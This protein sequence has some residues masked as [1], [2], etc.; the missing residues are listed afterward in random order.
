MGATTTLRDTGNIPGA[1]QDPGCGAQNPA[2]HPS[3]DK[4]APG[5]CLA[6]S[7]QS[8]ESH[9]DQGSSQS[10]TEGWDKVKREVE[11][12]SRICPAQGWDKL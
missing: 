2:P 5:H 8:G 11:E 3:G 12:W 7:S 10:L 6:R 4:D 9:Q 1:E